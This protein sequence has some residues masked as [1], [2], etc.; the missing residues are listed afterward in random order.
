MTAAFHDHGPARASGFS[1][2]ELLVGITIALIG[3]V[4]MFQ[5][6]ENSE[7]RKRTTAAGSDA[8]IAG[9]I[10]MHNL[11][12]DVR[13]GGNGF[14]S[15]TAVGCTVNAYD[16][17]RGSAFT[18]P[19]VPV[20]IIDGAAGAPD[21]IIVL[22]GNAAT[23]A[24]AY[25]FNESTA[26]SKKM[27]STSSRGGLRRGDIVFVTGTSCGLIEITDNTHIDQLTINHAA[28]A[29]TNALNEAATARFNAPGGFT[30]PSGQL[31]S[32]GENTLPRRN[33]WQIA[34][35]RT[36]TVTDDLHFTGAM[37]VGEGI[38]NLQAEYGLDTD[39]DFQADTW[40]AADPAPWTQAIAI[41]VALLAR[42]QQYEKASVTTTPPTWAA[43]AFV[44]TNLDG[45]ADSNPDDPND[46][47]HY[48][49]RVY[50]T[51][52]PLRNM[53]WGTTP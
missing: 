33:I 52:I 47:R 15:S 37:E 53:I 38:V 18:F 6:M 36:L 30:I 17:V 23:A 24:T 28:G 4:I 13:L 9:S 39:G 43:G 5:V 42:S 27:A 50:Q 22:Y 10:A 3:I 46:W 7:N 8:Q 14:G 34:N 2:I 44:M 40:Q 35:G 26:T 12:R 20:Q 19:M 49:Y 11:E 1:L 48:R 25:N 51:T 21:Q 31:F 16:T 32:L 29:Y 41:R 45:S